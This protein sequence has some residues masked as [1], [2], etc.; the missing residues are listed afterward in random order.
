MVCLQP[1]IKNKFL[2]KRSFTKEA[3]I[4]TFYLRISLLWLVTDG[5]L[6]KGIAQI[7]P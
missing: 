1:D 4:L 3:L 2:V 7:R 6:H 5:K